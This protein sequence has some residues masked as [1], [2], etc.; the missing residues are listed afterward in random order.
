[1]A[2]SYAFSTTSP[3]SW[4]VVE[5]DAPKKSVAGAELGRAADRRRRTQVMADVRRRSASYSNKADDLWPTKS[6]NFRKT[7]P[8][9]FPVSFVAIRLRRLTSV[10]GCSKRLYSIVD[11]GPTAQSPMR[12]EE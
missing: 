9:S 2:I 5:H 10:C 4:P 6:A 1:M 11:L 3:G 8:S 7:L 12:S